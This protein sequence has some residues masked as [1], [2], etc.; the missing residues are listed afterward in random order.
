MDRYPVKSYDGS[1]PQSISD[2]DNWL[3]WNG[4]LG[5]PSD[6]KDDCTA[7]IQSGIGEGNGTED[8]ESPAQQDMSAT[9]NV[10]RFIRPSWRSK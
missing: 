4:N 1:T 5:N 10:A 7:D 9:E 2:L 8:P 3:N 6:S